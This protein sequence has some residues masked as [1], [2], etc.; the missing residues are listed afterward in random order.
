VRCGTVK[1][2]IL[3][4]LGLFLTPLI[5]EAQQ[6]GKM[7]RIGHL[8]A[9]S[10]VALADEA[11]RHG[12]QELGYVE[13][14]IIPIV[15][16]GVGSD[17]VETGLVAS[18]AR[19][20][21]NLTGLIGFGVELSRKRLELLAEVVPRGSR[22]AVLWDGANPANRR[23]VQEADTAAQAL[24]LTVQAWEVHGTEGFERVFAALTQE[25]PD[26]LSIAGGPLMGA[27]RKRIAD[28]AF[29][30]RLPSVYEWRGAVEAGGL[31]SYGPNGAEAQ[32]RAATYVDKILKGAR[33][34]DLPVEQPMKFE[35][36]LNLK[37]A[38]TLGITISPTLL[39]LA[40]EVI[41]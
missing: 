4:A 32:R 33:P 11:F 19:P 38:Q 8:T 18:L 30:S 37:T 35:L 27:N 25:R 1:S 24:G 26:A 31:M 36:V 20:G 3:L 17:P 12:L 10:P 14:Q 7:P 16:V 29:Q 9:Q 6:A 5:T 23:N 39:L 22:V 15:M 40:D 28:F 21:G 13:G 2:I 41:K 34:V